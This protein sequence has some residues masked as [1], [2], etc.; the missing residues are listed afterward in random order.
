[1]ST[2]E[3][4]MKK[5]FS[6]LEILTSIG[7]IAVLSSIMVPK[8]FDTINSAKV[9]KSRSEVRTISEAIAQFYEHTKRWPNRSLEENSEIK[10]I[11]SKGELPEIEHESWR[12][13]EDQTS[14]LYDHLIENNLDYPSFDN[15]LLIGWNGKYLIDDLSDPW[16][17]QY[18]VNIGNGPL[19]Q[20]VWVLSAGVDGVIYS[21]AN[22]KELEGD[23]IGNR[24]F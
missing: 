7:I 15:E 19:D 5:G 12:F 23:D 4:G 6:L 3:I 21:N 18:W 1:M 14:P 13:S 10:M 16:G 8:L 17:K 20:S 2:W 9:S 24:I 11:Y 22:G